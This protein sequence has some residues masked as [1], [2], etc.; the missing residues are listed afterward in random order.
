M[1]R[2]SGVLLHISSLP[3]DDGI[4]SLGKNAFQF[5]DFLAQ[6]KQKI[7]QILPLGPTG[8]GNS[9]YQCYSAFAGNPLLIDVQQLVS[10]R[11]IAKSSVIGQHFK[12][13]WVEFDRVEEWK[14]KLFREAYVGF[15]KNFHRFQHEYHEF[16]RHNAWWLDDY[17]LFRALKANYE[18]TVWN[19]WPQKLVKRDKHSLQVAFRELHGEIDFHRFL[20][21][22]FFRQWFKLKEYAN[23]KGIRIIGDIPLYVSLDSVDVWANQ[24][25]FL[26]DSEA[27]PTQVGGV[28]P[29][30]FSETGQ[31]WGNPVF[32]WERVAERDFDWWLARLHFNL[33]MFDLVRVDHFRGLESFWA[34]AA[35][36]ETAIVG[37][38]LPA[39]GHQLFS[40]LREHLGQLNV[41]AEDLGII[42]PEVEKLRD[43]F[44]LPGMKVL[45][46]GFGSDV[47]N[48][49]L[50]HNFSTN[51]LVYTGTHD[52]DTSLGW[53]NTFDKKSR[54]L[55][56]KYVAGSGKQFVR[57]FMELAW[58]SVAHTAIVPMQDV[59][60]LGSE[61]RM[62]TPGVAG[63]NWGWRFTWPQIRTNHKVFLK[64][65]TE[66]YNR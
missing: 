54:R 13:K 51:F 17:A 25:I 23:S 3:G 16:M 9:P 10:D 52:N 38:W 57:N 40:K 42:T 37:K 30:Y 64:Q 48:E 41:I 56:H 27:R 39:R 5:V 20:Q 32:D 33:R 66:K 22:L 4:G 63:G 7:W 35:E 60:G 12:D 21:F 58:S 26:L 29:D 50:P 36:A 59:L 31:L 44:Q 19:T 43:D 18:D 15:Q 11:L 49:N 46:F 62:N 45:Q 47:K 65:I 24:D 53:Y 1:E 2:N 61:A 14:T 28:P 34:V 55:L 6:T 8:F